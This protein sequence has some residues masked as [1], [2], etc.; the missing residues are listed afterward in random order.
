MAGE[1]VGESEMI[2]IMKLALLIAATAGTLLAADGPASAIPTFESLGL[3]YNRPAAKECKVQY[4]VA[5]SATWRPGYPLVYDQRERQY[6]GS[7]VGL[8]PN[9]LYDIRLEADGQS[10]EIQARTRSE[11]FPIGKTTH[12]PGGTT[13]QPIS[14]REGGTDKAWHL[15]TPSPGT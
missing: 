11:E 2:K 13:D 12:L 7:L 8:T 6:R 4:R 5:G 1:V 9:T 14:I 10:V 15:V 3:Y